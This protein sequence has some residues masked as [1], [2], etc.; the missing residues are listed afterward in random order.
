M[1]FI[2]K[3]ILKK[4]FLKHKIYTMFYYKSMFISDDDDDDD[5]DVNYFNVFRS[6]RDFISNSIFCLLSYFH[7]YITF[8]KFTAFI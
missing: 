8:R 7:I 3:Y 5:D 4:L 2:F 6:L 1:Q